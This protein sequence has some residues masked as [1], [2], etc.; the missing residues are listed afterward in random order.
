MEDFM[1][2]SLANQKGGVCKTTTA[3]AL[4]AGLLERGRKVLL[5]DLDPQSNLSDAL[6]VENSDVSIYN[7]LKNE[8]PIIDG[9]KQTNS[10]DLGMVQGN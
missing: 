10:G 2:I 4:G 8:I 1:I 6:G 9:I 7:I 3:Q 5:I